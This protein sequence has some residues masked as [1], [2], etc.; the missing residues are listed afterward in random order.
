MFRHNAESIKESSRKMFVSEEEKTK[1]DGKAEL[2]HNHDDKHYTKDEIDNLVDKATVTLSGKSVSY[3]TEKG[4]IR[5]KEILGN[6]EQYTESLQDIK[7]VGERCHDGKYK[8]T[9]K[10]V[11]DKKNLYNHEDHTSYMSHI[12]GITVLDNGIVFD[13]SENSNVMNDIVKTNNNISLTDYPFKDKTSYVLKYN[14]THEGDLLV[15][16][17]ITFTDGSTY[18]GNE[19]NEEQILVTPA[20]KTIQRITY[21]WGTQRNKGKTTI[22]NIMIYE[23]SL[24]TD[25]EALP[26]ETKKLDIFLPVPLE[27]VHNKYR[28]RLFKDSDGMWKIE[29][30]VNT[31]AIPREN[32]YVPSEA[33]QTDESIL[34]NSYQDQLNIR[35]NVSKFISDQYVY[36][37]DLWNNS[38][39]EGFFLHINK[40]LQFRL[41][42]SEFPNVAALQRF[43]DG[44]R[45]IMKY[46]IEEPMIIQLNEPIPEYIESFSGDVSV[47]VGTISMYEQNIGGG[48]TCELPVSKKS[49]I[50]SIN[51]NISNHRERIKKIDEISS[52]TNLELNVTDNYVKEL[53]TKRGYIDDIIMEGKTLKNLVSTNPESWSYA[54]AD[55]D[56]NGTLYLFHGDDVNKYYLCTSLND[57]QVTTDK[58]YKLVIDVLDNPTKKYLGVSTYVGYDDNKNVLLRYSPFTFEGYDPRTLCKAPGRYVFNLKTHKSFTNDRWNKG[59]YFC[60]WDQTG[61]GA[62]EQMNRIKFRVGLFEDNG[63]F[64]PNTVQLNNKS[65]LLSVGESSNGIE[66]ISRKGNTNLLDD[67]TN[68]PRTNFHYSYDIPLKIHNTHQDI[69]LLELDPKHIKFV[70]KRTTFGI[71][72]IVKVKPNSRYTFKGDLELLNKSVDLG[73]DSARYSIRKLTHKEAWDLGPNYITDYDYDTAVGSYMYLSDTGKDTGITFTTKSDTQYVFVGIAS[74]YNWANT[75]NQTPGDMTIGVRNIRLTEEK[76]AS[77]ITGEETVECYGS[78]VTDLNGNPIVLRALP[79]GVKDRIFKEN[80]EYF[81]TKN[82]NLTT[83]NGSEN[84]L[85]EGGDY[86]SPDVL[87]LKLGITSTDIKNGREV[88]A[89]RFLTRAYNQNTESIFAYASNTHLILGI[90]KSRLETPDVEGAKKWLNKNPITV[91][92]ETSKPVTVPIRN[93][94]VPTHQGQTEFYIESGNVAPVFKSKISSHIGS[95]VSS[96]LDKVRYV[97]EEVDIINNAKLLSSALLCDNKAKINELINSTNTK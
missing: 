48:M 94:S 39:K 9:I 41:K 72:W 26:N 2:V 55:I 38:T 89:D 44:T 52:S 80:G 1:W 5:I 29:K 3:T 56:T 18:A 11:N 62:I 81:Y 45:P 70:S 30:H 61:S 8:V 87:V 35:P 14:P 68:I 15:R 92:Y 21:S 76:I 69:E 24:G 78:K 10:V 43:I 97:E 7:S 46:V 47:Y 63:S 33:V 67:L 31:V 17:K 75:G 74:P 82:I 40:S 79:N 84:W 54:G 50:K 57:T 32:W 28:D 12:K 6:T 22:E 4:L 91:I 90:L 93:I 96:L 36:Q 86:Y 37:D 64:D 20:S 23:A 42:R 49:V 13:A 34:F 60:I 19:N 65:G 66:L 83:L 16:L 59:L 71:G 25:I 95:T 27:M 77:Q 51:D 53:D 58:R 73:M 85:I 88:L